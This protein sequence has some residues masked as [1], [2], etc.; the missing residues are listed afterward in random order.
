MARLTFP[1]EGSRLVYDATSDRLAPPGTTLQLFADEALTVPA[2]LTDLV[3]AALTSGVVTVGRGGLLNLFKGPADGSDTL[4][5][6]GSGGT[7]YPVYARADD[8]LDALALRVA[9]TEA[10][11]AA[12]PSTYALG[13][14]VITNVVLDADGNWTSWKE[15]GLSWSATYDSVTGSMLTQTDPAGHTRT[16][17]YDGD[18]NLT[19][20]A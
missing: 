15:N 10:V 18:G 2:D 16:F 7:A 20:A 12:L 5:V 13:N 14:P 19:G 1:D 9:A 11:G 4:W 8:R 17:S 6:E 3:G